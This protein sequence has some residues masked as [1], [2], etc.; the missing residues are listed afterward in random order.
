MTTRLSKTI[1]TVTILITTLLMSRGGIP[2]VR[3]AETLDLNQGRQRQADLFRFGNNRFMADGMEAPLERNQVKDWWLGTSDKKTTTT[4]RKEK[5]DLEQ[6]KIIEKLKIYRAQAQEMAARHPG[7]RGVH[8]IDN[9][10]HIL[11][12]DHRQVYRYHFVGLVLS[13]EMLA[14]ADLA[15]GFSEGRSRSRIVFARTLDPNDVLHTLNPDE[16]NVT[17]PSRGALFFDPKAR[18]LNA[19][20]AGVEVGSIVEYAYE[21][22]N[23]APEDWRI[24][25]PTYYFQSEI[26]VC[27][28]NFTVQ[29]PGELKLYAWTE[30]W[31]ADAKTPKSFLRRV[32]S[33]LKPDRRQPDITCFTDID[34]NAYT[35]HHW[36]KTNVPPITTEPQMPPWTE[37]V[38]AVHATIMKDWQHLNQLTGGMQK[39]RLQTTPEIQKLAEQITTGLA[40]DEDKTA[41]T[42]HWVQKNI[43]YISIKSSLSSG[44]AGHP[45]AETLA[46]G[47]GDCTDKSVLF[48]TLLQCLGIAA[49][50]VVLR[51]NDAGVFIPRHPVLACNHCITQI[52]LPKGS[53]YLDATSQDYRFPAFR[54]D[55]HGVFAINF[56]RGEQRII[57]LPP[58]FTAN[59]KVTVSQL[60]LQPDD[61]LQVQTRNLYTGMY[62]ANLRA[63]WKRVPEQ[64]RRQ[65]MQQYLNGTAPGANLLQFDMGA[66][67]DL[68]H[69]FFL[70]YDY[71]LPQYCAQ[72]GQY[73][74]FQFP[75]RQLDFPENALEK[76]RYPLVYTTANGL[77]RTDLLTIPDNLEV[78]QMPADFHLENTH[79]QYHETFEQTPEGI[80]FKAI[81]TRTSRHIPPAEYPEYREATLRI[82]QQTKKPLYLK[83]ANAASTP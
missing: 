72:A 21:Y 74:L 53:I 54:G 15:L 33:A 16:M 1:S 39:E 27:H 52:H 60:Q 82:Q 22:E 12:S 18:V 29:I 24:F 66:P 26:P 7:V 68:A 77:E 30:N 28:S 20:L 83:I 63:S 56:I 13:E 14:W 9:G 25:F 69:Q 2:R 3:G 19:T 64:A 45:A 51:T 70:A 81:L 58:P 6:R 67:E 32:A 38:P 10:R 71:R 23:Y 65:V 44:W 49:E 36:S 41:A 62:E 50:P 37:V 61:T 31:N 4:E 47:Y 35:L 55:D 76:R 17:K 73:R 5:T 75:D 8:V 46:Q 78:A 34:G 79:I 59:G 80:R 42:Y 48:A 11:T 40:T 43:R 57:E